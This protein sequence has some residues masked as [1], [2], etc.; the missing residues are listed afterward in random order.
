MVFGLCVTVLVQSLIQKDMLFDA[1]DYAHAYNLVEKFPPVH[2][3]KNYLR[4]SKQRIY[5][6][7]KSSSLQQVIILLFLF[8][9]F[10][11]LSHVAYL[12]NSTLTMD[13]VYH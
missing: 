8:F 13:F 11:F 5:G 7:G 9:L 2:L 3:L 12:K 1:V 10:C 6:E 4:L